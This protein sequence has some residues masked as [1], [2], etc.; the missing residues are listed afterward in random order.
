[1]NGSINKG[2]E[3]STVHGISSGR[4][5]G[6]SANKLNSRFTH[7][8]RSHG[9]GQSKQKTPYIPGLTSGNAS[10]HLVRLSV[11]PNT[12]KTKVAYI[13]YI[14]PACTTK[15]ENTVESLGFFRILNHSVHTKSVVSQYLA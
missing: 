8:R 11:V 2:R 14:N 9:N 5:V 6:S 10:V 12:H 13:V 7:K 3:K 4:E 1:M 15:R